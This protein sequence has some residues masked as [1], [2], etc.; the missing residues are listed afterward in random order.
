MFPQSNVE[1]YMGKHGATVPSV[2]MITLFWPARQFHSAKCSSPFVSCTKPGSPATC[3]AMSPLVPVPSPFQPSP[4]RSEPLAIRINALISCRRCT[5]LT[6]WY[7]AL[8]FFDQ[9]VD[10]GIDLRP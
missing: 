8:F 1:A 3:L 2:R 9:P 6:I 5:E 10:Q 4:F 7:P